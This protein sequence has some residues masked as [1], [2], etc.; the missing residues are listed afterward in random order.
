MK[1]SRLRKKSPSFRQG[2]R[3]GFQDGTR[4]KTIKAGD[5]ESSWQQYLDEMKEQNT[6]QYLA[7]DMEGYRRGYT[8]GGEQ[9]DRDKTDLTLAGLSIMAVISAAVGFGIGIAVGAT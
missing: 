2:Y 7:G 5:D 9:R 6:E 4:A 1:A 3:N 8:D